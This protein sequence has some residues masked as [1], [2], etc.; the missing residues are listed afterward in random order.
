MAAGSRWRVDGL[1][2]GVSLARMCHTV[3]ERSRPHGLFDN[4]CP[5]PGHVRPAVEGRSIRRPRP[6]PTV[7]Q[8]PWVTPS[9]SMKKP[10]IWPRSVIPK[11]AVAVAPGTSMGVNTPLSKRKP[12]LAPLVSVK[13][14]TIWPRALIPTAVVNVAPGTSIGVKVRAAGARGCLSAPPEASGA[15]A[16]AGVTRRVSAHARTTS[17]WPSVARRRQG[18]RC[19]VCPPVGPTGGSV[20][21]TAIRPCSGMRVLKS[22]GRP[23]ETPR[24]ALRSAHE[25][26]SHSHTGVI[27]EDVQNRTLRVPM[28]RTSPARSD[29]RRLIRKSSEQ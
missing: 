23:G 10:T 19:M 22:G 9:A 21:Y 25:P 12:R 24:T 2:A 18:I 17:A 4:A 14:P 5:A 15:T 7:P 8:K 3:S 26:V 11:A 16:T 13:L 6:C 1:T 28:T 29:G 20:R 27:A